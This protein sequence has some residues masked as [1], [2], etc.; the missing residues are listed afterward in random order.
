M[1]PNIGS[2][3]SGETGVLGGRRVPKDSALVEALGAIDEAS[4]AV[5]LARAFVRDTHR[6][7]FL[8]LCQ[9]AL[10]KCGAEV[11]AAGSPRATDFD[12][13]AAAKGLEAEMERLAQLTE[14]PTKFLTPGETP[15]EAAL[16]LARAVTRRAE[17]AVVAARRTGVE[18]EPGAHVYIN[19]LSDLLFDMLCA[20]AAGK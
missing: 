6:K 8:A 19:R 3:D 17:R 11:A 13:V 4:A 1:K 18:F 9:A 12:F 2:G 5:G 7:A 14:R 20:E 16:N 15:A 10:L